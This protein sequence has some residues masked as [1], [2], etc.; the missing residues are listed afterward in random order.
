MVEVDSIALGNEEKK[1]DCLICAEK[2]TYFGIPD[3]CNHNMIC[4]NCIL[5]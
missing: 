3:T 1:E 2:V 4:W 5:K